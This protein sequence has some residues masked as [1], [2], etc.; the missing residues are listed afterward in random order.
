M[1]KVHFIV[2]FIIFSFIANAQRFKPYKTFGVQANYAWSYI[3][4]DGSYYGERPYAGL[5]TIDIYGNYEIGVRK[6]LGVSSG[7]GFICRGATFSGNS[8][9]LSNDDGT[10]RQ[11]FYAS[12]PLLVQ[13]K[14]FK[15]FWL[16][17]GLQANTAL[18]HNDVGAVNTYTYSDGETF[19]GPFNPAGLSR[20]TVL[21]QAGFRVN[22]YRG[23]SLFANF[24]KD[25]TPTV[26]QKPNWFYYPNAEVALGRNHGISLGF[27]YMF[28]QPK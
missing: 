16:E 5:N 9:Y 19:E 18:F 3:F 20:F 27:R 15:G 25:I 24:Y 23:L 1:K 14:P 13:L 12:V 22:L 17:G 2:I 11:I 7:L 6:W 28:N 21:W 10:T 8:S 4:F 26:K